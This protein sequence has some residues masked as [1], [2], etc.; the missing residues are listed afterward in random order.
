MWRCSVSPSR[1]AGFAAT[2]AGPVEGL[3]ALAHG[4]EPVEEVERS[5]NRWNL[6][7]GADI[8]RLNRLSLLE[9]S[10]PEL[11]SWTFDVDEG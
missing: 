3:R 5:A 9:A 4:H 11:R 1:S 6:D 8:R 2:E 7:T 10:A